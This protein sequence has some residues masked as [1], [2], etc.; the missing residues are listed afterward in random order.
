MRA[1]T[2]LIAA[3]FSLLLGFMPSSA[4]AFPGGRGGGGSDRGGGGEMHEGFHGGF[5]GDFDRG[6]RG[7]RDGG[8]RSPGFYIGPS[9]G[10]GWGYGWGW[11]DPWFWGGPYYYPGTNVLELRHA[12]YGTL[13]FNVK[14]QDTKVFVDKKFIGTVGELDHHKAYVAA[15]NHEIML[16]APDGKTMERNV[17]VAA[18]KKVKIDERF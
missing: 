13:E 12:N 4:L 5:H 7:D 2:W 14:P 18:G 3:A 10:L 11:G 6:F 8:F 15:G 16:Q 17:Y 1:K 9:Y